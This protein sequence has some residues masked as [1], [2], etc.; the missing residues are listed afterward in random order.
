M[1]KYQKVHIIGIGGAGMNGIA[2]ILL[3]MGL[4]VTGSDRQKT[5]VVEMLEQKG[6]TIYEEN[7]TLPLSVCDL[8][9]MSSA[10]SIEHTVVKEAVK[11]NIP[12][13]TRHQLFK[14]IF[15]ERD[16]IAIS[17]S[18]GKTTTTSLTA[19]VL[20]DLGLNCGYSVGVPDPDRGGK[21]G[22]DYFVIEADEYAKTLLTLKPKIAVI[23]NI[24]WDHVDIYPSEE[25]YFQVFREFAEITLNNK[26]I[27]IANSDDK[28]V[29]SVLEGLEY[30]SFGFESHNQFYIQNLQHSPQGISF[31]VFENGNES[32]SINSPLYGQHNALNALV[33]FIVSKQLQLSDN[34]I[35]RAINNFSGVARRAEIKGIIGDNVLVMDDYAHTAKEIQTT[36]QGLKSAYPDRRLIAI[37]QPHTFSRIRDFETE[38]IEAC[39]YADVMIITQVYGARE[40]GEYDFGRFA[41]SLNPD[42]SFFLNTQ[43]EIKLKLKDLILPDDILLTLNAGDLYKLGED[44][45]A[46]GFV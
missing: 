26:G 22:Q 17:G 43:A 16:L 12:V 19:S 29:R 31:Q 27:L 14:E 33:S 2:N 13:W 39:I 44:L 28:N 9:L 32:T 25:E 3:Q 24:D 10:V 40:K 38:F 20:T 35:K 5:K 1:L 15:H 4:K 41:Q 34:D 11:K 46:N 21:W 30:I 18:H 7:D 36:I 42:K 6:I 37:W 23:N 8:L 45:V